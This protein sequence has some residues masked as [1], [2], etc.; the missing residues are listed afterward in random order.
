[1]VAQLCVRR[2][3]VRGRPA[4]GVWSTVV[5]WPQLMHCQT[6]ADPPLRFYS[7]GDRAKAYSKVALPG[8]LVAAWPVTSGHCSVQLRGGDDRS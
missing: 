8:R 6:E 2:S 1:M 4:R 5:Q 3:P 7:V